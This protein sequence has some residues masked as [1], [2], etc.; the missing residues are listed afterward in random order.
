MYACYRREDAAQA[1]TMLDAVAAVL[2]EYPEEVIR[3]V[4]DPRTG[5]PGRMKFPPAVAEVREACEL[6]MGPIKAREERD[7]RQS[8]A[9]V[10]IAERERLEEF[11][12]NAPKVDLRERHAEYFDGRAGVEKPDEA[13]RRQMSHIE[14]AN[15]QLFH[16]ECVAAN[17]DPGKA[18]VSPTLAAII[19]G[20][21]SEAA[22]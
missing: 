21:K 18:Q 22:E 4:T 2:A 10:Q 8:A 19:R 1:E 12:R 20:P 16:N 7:R 3:H 6:A 14:A 9:A 5:L 17:V 15:R 13:R 11:Y